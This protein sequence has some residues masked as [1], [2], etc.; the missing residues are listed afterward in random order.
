MFLA[1]GIKL[2][3]SFIFVYLISKKSLEEVG[4]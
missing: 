4:K 3:I 1:W 2:G